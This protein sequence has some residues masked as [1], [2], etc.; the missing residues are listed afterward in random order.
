M[1]E[2]SQD[3]EPIEPTSAQ[4]KNNQYMANSLDMNSFDVIADDSVHVESPTKNKYADAELGR[5]GSYQTTQMTSVSK[6]IDLKNN[7]L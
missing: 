6:S 2:R 1:E 4:L 7:N 5:C 3:D